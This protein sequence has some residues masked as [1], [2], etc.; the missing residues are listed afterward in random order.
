MYRTLRA[1]R[2]LHITI[3]RDAAARD[4]TSERALREFVAAL[5]D[6]LA[7]LASAAP[8]AVAVVP[9]WQALCEVTPGASCNPPAATGVADVYV[10]VSTE[11]STGTREVP[12]RI[13]F[14]WPRE[15][16]RDSLTFAL[17]HGARWQWLPVVRRTVARLGLGVN[18]PDRDGEE[19]VDTAEGT[20][21]LRAAMTGTT[22]ELTRPDLRAT[23]TSGWLSWLRSSVPADPPGIREF[24]EE[25]AAAWTSRSSG[26]VRALHT[27]MSSEQ[28]LDI[29]EYFA[30]V[31]ELDVAFSDVAL[32]S[33]AD[34]VLVSAWRIDRATVADVGLLT[35]RTRVDL[36]LRRLAGGW[37]LVD[38]SRPAALVW[39]SPP[40]RIA[41]TETRGP[42]SSRT[43]APP[44]AAAIPAPP[45]TDRRWRT[46][47]RWVV[48]AGDDQRPLRDRGLTV[49]EIATLASDENRSRPL[50]TAV[51]PPWVV[52]TEDVGLNDQDLSRRLQSI[53]Q[54]VVRDFPFLKKPSEPAVLIVFASKEHSERFWDSL[55][56]AL[57]L[58]P[59]Q[60]PA[61]YRG[62]A[63]LGIG[64][65]WWTEDV[66]ESFLTRVCV[67]EGVHA[68]MDQMLD[69][70]NRSES[71]FA[72]GLASRYDMKAVD[73]DVGGAV[74]EA[75]QEGNFPGVLELMAA[76]RLPPHGYVP[77]A[78]IIDW[79][80]ADPLRRS[81]LPVLY[82]ELHVA[83]GTP[84]GPLLERNLGMSISR[85]DAE[86]HAWVANRYGNAP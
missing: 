75:L 70:G 18:V 33:N 22:V 13:T 49:A 15:S 3:V 74:R 42:S 68:L 10:V 67:H 64:T 25:Y 83:P 61:T 8:Q 76:E 39:A 4:A 66:T 24:L 17:P 38:Q 50:R 16:R 60:L 45:P 6:S 1:E 34:R 65:T 73:F 32:T 43:V 86:W 5:R 11:S 58:R 29:D 26:R 28:R 21:L 54:D 85:L 51:A 71:W 9:P 44:I 62:Q 52:M 37:R 20:Q 77:A 63:T 80:L 19:R 72:E 40:R 23:P 2:P 30:F 7:D 47:P 56:K 14:V 81:Q 55:E 78:L 82:R 79:L 69:V 57:E 48:S 59:P 46:L 41:S 27:A 35:L 36:M 31:S 84:L 12:F 53:Y